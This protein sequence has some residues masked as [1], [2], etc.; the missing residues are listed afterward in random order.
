MLMQPK[1]DVKSGDRVPIAL[2]FAGG[3][4]IRMEFKVRRPTPAARAA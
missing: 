2:G 4:T 1:K 3:Q